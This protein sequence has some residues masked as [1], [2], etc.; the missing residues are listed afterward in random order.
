MPNTVTNQDDP[1]GNASQLDPQQ[2]GTPETTQTTPVTRPTRREEPQAPIRLVE[3]AVRL[4]PLIRDALASYQPE[5]GAA[6][7]Q[8]VVRVPLDNLVEAACILKENPLLDFN[9]FR[10]L[11]TVDYIEYFELVYILYSTRKRHQVLLKTTCPY[12]KASA[13]S[14]IPV[15]QAADWFER[16]S[17]DLF[18]VLFE[19]HPNLKPLL[20]YDGFEGYPGRKSF[21]FN[22]YEDW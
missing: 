21:A 18:G 16:E 11:A 20:L 2:T 8:L 13:P 22:D 19:G 6:V 14:L 15:W 12:E 9:Y 10:C 4:E 7:D 5:I 3:R 17:H 1:Q